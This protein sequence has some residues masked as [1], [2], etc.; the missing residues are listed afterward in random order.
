M[1]NCGGDSDSLGSDDQQTLCPDK[2]MRTTEKEPD[3]ADEPTERPSVFNAILALAPPFEQ[4][5]FTPYA[6]PADNTPS[7]TKPSTISYRK[8]NSSSLS[9]VPNNDISASKTNTMQAHLE[10]NV[11]VEESRASENIVRPIGYSI[12]KS[13]RDISELPKLHES[14][15]PSYG[16]RELADAINSVIYGVALFIVF[17]IFITLFVI[18]IG[19]RIQMNLSQRNSRGSMAPVVAATAVAT[20]TIRPS[21]T[22][23]VITRD[24]T[25]CTTNPQTR[26][27]AFSSS[28]TTVVLVT[29]PQHSQNGD[30]TTYDL[31]PS[32]DTLFPSP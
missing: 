5:R 29:L 14:D 8:P 10:N 26:E 2:P 31:P 25:S 6:S 32:Y 16:R 7:P 20:P 3:E 19:R 13:N 9:N 11:L 18:Y 21:T 23:A 12:S 24:N 4:R 15:D 27:L 28:N 17:T 30:A 22:T 1:Y